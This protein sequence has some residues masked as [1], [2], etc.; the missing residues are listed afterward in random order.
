[1]EIFEEYRSLDRD[2]KVVTLAGDMR[3]WTWL[4]SL[5]LPE[6]KIDLQK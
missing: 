6:K 3:D 1:M 4:K 5:S 2:A